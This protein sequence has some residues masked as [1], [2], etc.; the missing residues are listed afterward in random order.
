M[1]P[2]TLAARAVLFICTAGFAA[3]TGASSDSAASDS[4]ATTG[5]TGTVDSA[6]AAA[7]M[8]GAGGAAATIVNAAG[9]S[10][11]AATFRTEGNDVRIEMTARALPDGAHG[12]HLHA[13]GTCE[14]PSFESAGGHAN[15]TGAKHGVKNPAGPHAG[16]LPNA[17]GGATTS[18]SASTSRM[19]LE[20]GENAILDADGTAIVIHADPDDDVTDPSG[21]SGARIACGVISRR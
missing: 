20:G 7:A 3:C 19:T 5:T 1:T 10:I 6:G 4:A 17:M 21:N 2:S 15:P 11:G 9:D 8:T 16:D 13:V 14:G 12:V 18:Y